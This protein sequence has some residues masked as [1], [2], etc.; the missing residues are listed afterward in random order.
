[1]HSKMATKTIISH[2]NAI[3]RRISSQQSNLNFSSNS[4]SIDNLILVEN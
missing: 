1:M 2:S 3:T 4:C